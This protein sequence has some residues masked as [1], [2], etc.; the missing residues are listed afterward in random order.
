MYNSNQKQPIF[1]E[2]VSQIK[3]GI[4]KFN[5]KYMRTF[6]EIQTSKLQDLV[7]QPGDATKST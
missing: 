2:I 5:S 1:K 4:K 6:D 7:T 3:M